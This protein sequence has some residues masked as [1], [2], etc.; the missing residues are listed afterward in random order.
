MIERF[1]I[2]LDLFF[3]FEARD[4]NLLIKVIMIEDNL[5][6]LIYIS[7]MHTRG[8]CGLAAFILASKTRPRHENLP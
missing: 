1:T 4:K 3:C 6:M 2:C 8:Q 7:G 5:K